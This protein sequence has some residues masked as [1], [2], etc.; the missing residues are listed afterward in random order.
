VTDDATQ[1]LSSA[2]PEPPS[3]AA[4]AEMYGAHLEMEERMLFGSGGK[5]DDTPLFPD[6]MGHWLQAVLAPPSS[7]GPPYVHDLTPRPCVPCSDG[8]ETG[9]CGCECHRPKVAYTIENL[10]QS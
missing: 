1:P 10:E 8:C 7:D 2:D 5:P 9:P 3:S 4:I 6:A